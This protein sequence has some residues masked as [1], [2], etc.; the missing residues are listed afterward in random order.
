MTLDYF[1]ITGVRNIVMRRSTNEKHIYLNQ[2]ETNYVPSRRGRMS[3]L[4]NG[5][6]YQEDGIIVVLD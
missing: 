5:L 3:E 4:K 6:R 2:S 1:V